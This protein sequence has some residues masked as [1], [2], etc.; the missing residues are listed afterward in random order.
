[1]SRSILGLDIRKDAVSAVL[2]NN[3]LK[4]NCIEAHIHVPISDKGTEKG[5]PEALE[6]I[7]A[8][9][10]TAHSACIASFP[11][12]QVSFRNLSVPFKEQNKIRQM[13]PFE[14]EPTLP[15]PLDD[16]VIDFLAVGLSD[17]TD[18]IAAAV[19]KSAIESYLKTLAE[20]DIDPE[21]VTPEGY[22]TVLCWI[23]FSDLPENAVMVD[24][25]NRK[26]TIFAVSSGR[27][28]LVR[29]LPID[30]TVSD[31]AG[32]L[33]TNI[34]RTLSAFEEISDLNFKP[35]GIW[36]TGCGSDGLS[37]DQDMARI[38]QTPVRRLDLIHDTRVPLKDSL[39]SWEPAQMD[40]AF[41][42]ALLKV[43]G[44]HGLNFR[45]GPF[46]TKKTW[47]ERKKS[48][49]KTGI[50]ACF[51]LMLGFFNIILDIHFMETK[52]T[53]LNNQIND[54]FREAFPDVKKIV[55]PLQQMRLK[56]QDA[57][58][59]SAIPG[60]S[61]NNIRNI[62]I[63]YHISRIIPTETD[64]ELS[65]LVIGAESA[66]ISGTTDT[67]NSVDDMKNRL[68]QNEFFKKVTISSANI[69]RSG[70]R[71]NFKLKIDL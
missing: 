32:S 34:Q 46:A 55:D 48:L 28:F 4:G 60:E 47:E 42:L 12:D 13:L 71:V 2:V 8:K 37:L 54:I 50:I 57:N 59:Y 16:L 27:I 31:R 18:L 6:I 7:A 25:D 49:I 39:S 40:N 62:D 19:E 52:L 56:I 22:S 36:V 14:L 61:H 23:R 35:D 3:S 63:L 58:K 64:V 30:L 44:I 29:S 67:F 66:L 53:R 11:S 5:I 9:L 41:A 38:L 65:G 21:I 33:C 68:E 1:M 51:V 45:K 15:F 20:F 70:N 69:E 17:H 43:E 10:D 24:I 26:S